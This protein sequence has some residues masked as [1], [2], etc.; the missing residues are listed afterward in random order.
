M[1]R[2][3]AFGPHGGGRFEIFF[4][5]IQFARRLARKLIEEDFFWRGSFGFPFQGVEEAVHAS[6]AGMERRR[7]KV[8]FFFF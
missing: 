6:R 8:F 2:C 4:G 3:S 1:L 5:V 7:G